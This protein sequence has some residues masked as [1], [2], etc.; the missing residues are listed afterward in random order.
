MTSDCQKY[1]LSQNKKPFLCAEK[2]M[3]NLGP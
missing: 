3:M 1:I 2:L